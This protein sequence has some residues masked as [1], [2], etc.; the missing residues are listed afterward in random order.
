MKTTFRHA[1]LSDLPY[2]YDIC[3]RTGYVG[4]DASEVL[5]DRHML[6]QY[7]AAPYVVYNADWCWVAVD[8][9]G[10]V[11][12]LVTT[13]NSQKYVT[14]MNQHWLPELR[15][16][17][18]P[19]AKDVSPFESWLR[20]YF[21]EDASFPDFADEYPAHLHIDFLPRAQGQGLGTQAI[22]LF[23][24]RLREAGVA[25]FHLGMGEKNSRAQQFYEK[26]GLTLI[27]HDPGVIYYGRQVR[28]A[29]AKRG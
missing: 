27:R 14:W 15:R 9:L 29:S 13:P 1:H 20:G 19:T 4:Q 11:G 21:H 3:H 28:G 10:P 17:Y 18:A 8:E 12:Y 26:I 22:G 24:N 6:G 2:L 5:P 25:G 23:E 7:F 16:R